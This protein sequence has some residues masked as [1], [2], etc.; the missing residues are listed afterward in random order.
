MNL[1]GFA[2]EKLLICSPI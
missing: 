1:N 2:I